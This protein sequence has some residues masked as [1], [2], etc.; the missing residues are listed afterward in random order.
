MENK[1]IS[2]MSATIL[3]ECLEEGI[4]EKEDYIVSEILN[5]T[6]VNQKEEMLKI[7][8]EKKNNDKAVCYL[9]SSG[10]DAGKIYNIL[11]NAIRT[12]KYETIEAL[13]RSGADVND[14]D[15]AALYQAYAIKNA[16]LIDL[17]ISYG[18][19]IGNNKIVLCYANIIKLYK[20]LGVDL[21]YKSRQT[22][23]ECIDDKD[24]EGI[25]YNMIEE[26]I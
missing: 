3:C 4:I 26:C 2:K 12:C 6:S 8:V 9:L 24:F 10:I 18:A 1:F 13:L 14:S 20:K 16:N 22:I 17:L 5:N 25:I 11:P 19:C 7:A 21:D 15:N 23:F